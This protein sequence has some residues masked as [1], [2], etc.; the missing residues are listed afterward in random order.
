MAKRRL[1]E[2]YDVEKH[3]GPSY[4]PWD[5]RLCLAPNGDLFKTIRK[6][7]ADVVTD[8]ID[9]FTETGI[10]LGSGA[11][12]GGRHHRHRNGFEP[13][14][15][16]WREI[17]RN[18]EPVDLDETMAYKGM[19]LTGHAE[20]GVHDRLHQRVVDA[21]GRPGVRVRLPRA[22]LHGRQRLRHR[23]AAASR[24]TTSTSGRSWTSLPATCCARW[25]TCRKPA[26]VRRGGSSRTTSGTSSSSGAAR[27]TTRR[28]TSPNTVR[29]WRFQLISWAAAV[30][31]TPSSSL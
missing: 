25:T 29:R 15:V 11:R 26:R 17:S 28:C 5:Q 19:M 6:G 16:R 18:G 13:A 23:G 3:F 1:P 21:E 24:A 30:T 8:T 22:E 7:K 12:A 2:G 10:K 20:H 4:N 27:S 14:A 9:R 31:T